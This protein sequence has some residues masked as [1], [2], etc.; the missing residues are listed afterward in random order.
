MKSQKSRW[1]AGLVAL[2]LL[3]TAAAR[4]QEKASSDKELNLRAYTELL[5]ADVKAKRVAIITEIMQFDDTEA[6]S[7]WPIFR[8]YDLE[9]SKIG[10]GRISLIED[11]IDNYENI[12]DQKADR[13]MTQ[14][15]AL[16][17]QRAELK[18]NYFDKMKR[19][20]SPVT[21]ARFFQIENQIQHIIDLQVS[22][23]LPTMQQA[24]K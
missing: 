2:L 4:T 15:F 11:Y 13:L 17:A 21:A 20:L 22:A 23:S 1:P 12:T 18:K 14:V 10:D 8:A 7:F 16:E 3:I 24:S 5:R 9:L 19:T 6:A